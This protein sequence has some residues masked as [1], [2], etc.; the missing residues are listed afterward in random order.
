MRECRRTHEILGGNGTVDATHVRDCRDC[1]ELLM[2]DRFLRDLA[3]AD[4]LSPSLPDSRVLLLKADFVSRRREVAAEGER[5]RWAGVG[6]WLAIAALWVTVLTWKLG[7]I[8]GLLERF[9]LVASIPGGAA[10]T[11]VFVAVAGGLLAFTVFAVAVHSVL[12]EM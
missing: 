3:S 4:D 8:Q 11:A 5:A 7:A 6:V 2:I 12:A 9:G 1:N 10:A